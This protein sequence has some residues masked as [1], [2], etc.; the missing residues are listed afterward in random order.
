MAVFLSNFCK[1]QQINILKT[2][3]LV[4]N[5][6]KDCLREEESRE[7][8]DVKKVMLLLI[9]FSGTADF[10]PLF[11]GMIGDSMISRYAC[12][13]IGFLIEAVGKENLSKT[14]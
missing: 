6:R 10:L 5:H 9:F 8:L 11:G 1:C 7:G 4:H 2:W 12:T 14:I 13:L 3:D